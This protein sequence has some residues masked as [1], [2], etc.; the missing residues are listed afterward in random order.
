M[1]EI[2]LRK[3]DENISYKKF[4]APTINIYD[5]KLNKKMAKKFMDFSPKSVKESS[6]NVKEDR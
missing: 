5:E 1:E 2:K 4:S 3:V 6:E